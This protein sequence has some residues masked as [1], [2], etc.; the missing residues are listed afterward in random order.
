MSKSP[1]RVLLRLDSPKWVPSNRR[2]TGT[3]ATM[4]LVPLPGRGKRGT[5]MVAR[6]NALPTLKELGVTKKRAAR[7]AEVQS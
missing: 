2:P 6:F 7:S 3:G 4:A 5:K 1:N